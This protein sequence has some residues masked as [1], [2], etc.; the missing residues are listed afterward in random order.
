MLGVLNYNL[1][2]PVEDKQL[3]KINLK[4]DKR[5]TIAE[6]HYK[7]LCIDE[8]KWCRKNAEII[9]NKANC[10]YELCMGKSNYKGKIRCLDFK[11]LEKECSRYNNK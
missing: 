8:L 5:D 3:V 11:K 10:L 6:K 2:I 1:M 7:Q 4:E 9:I